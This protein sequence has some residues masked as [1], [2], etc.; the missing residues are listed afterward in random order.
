MDNLDDNEQPIITEEVLL[1]D[2]EKRFKAA[3]VTSGETISI[4]RRPVSWLG[5]FTE[6]ML[7]QRG[8]GEYKIDGEEE[9]LA[10]GSLKHVVFIVHGIG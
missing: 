2:N 9:E 3:V 1:S 6:N 5:G 10:L 8:Y 7:I 4:R